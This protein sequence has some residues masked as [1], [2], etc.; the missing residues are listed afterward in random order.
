M[1][2][3]PAAPTLL[4]ANF[5]DGSCAL[6]WSPVPEAAG[7]KLYY[8]TTTGSYTSSTTVGNVTE[9]SIPALDNSKVYYIAVQAVNASNLLSLTS[10]EIRVAHRS[11]N[12]Q[13]LI[14]FKDQKV[15][16][17]TTMHNLTL[18]GYKFTAFGDDSLFYVAGPEPQSKWIK[19]PTH[20]LYTHSWGCD[21]R[22][23]R[24]D[25]KPFDLYSLDLCSIYGGTSIIIT[26][27]DPSSS[28]FRRIVNLPDKKEAF[29]VP[30]TLDWAN[31]TKVEIHWSEKPDGGGSQGRA[32]GVDN[33]L[34][35]KQA[36]APGN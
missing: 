34:F 11:A 5:G 18:Q 19:F 23:E 35:N 9:A 29:V 14:D 15:D 8:G 16:G 25:F 20:V 2:D 12:P 28:S 4:S 3:A 13:A 7:Y 27:Y 24:A 21:I 30:V 32:G 31:V 36:T 6:K 10:N 1:P 17:A 26:G 33:L 22:I